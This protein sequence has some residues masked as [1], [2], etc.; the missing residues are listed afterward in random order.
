MTLQAVAPVPLFLLEYSDIATLGSNL[1]DANGE[2][3]AAVFQAPKAGTID[4]VCFRTALVTTG[5]TVDVRLETVGA[6]GNPSGTLVGTNTNASQVINATDDNVWFE[7]TLTA[8]AVVTAGQLIAIVVALPASGAVG[9]MNIARYRAPNGPGLPFTTLFTGTW[10]KLSGYRP[11]A[12]VRYNDGSYPSIVGVLP[13]SAYTANAYNS[14]SSPDERG[15]KITLPVACKVIGAWFVSSASA[16]GDYS[17]KLYNVSD[18]LLTSATLDGDAQFP[19]AGGVGYVYFDAEVTLAAS[20]VVRL[21]KL[22]TTVTN[23]D[24]FSIT[25]GTN[26]AAALPGGTA[27]VRTTR[28]DA[29]AWTDT[30]GQ[31]H[32]IGLIVSALDDGASSG[33]GARA[34]G[35]VG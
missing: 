21:T 27:V 6:D 4:R 24:L 14:G 22:P 7:V 3:A 32:L 16:V 2:K 15:N 28:T 20:D 19:V 30:S 23:T 18:T 5:D 29:G 1:I 9:V 35:F 8:G 10:S 33:G 12:A 31:Q 13:L 17:I 34:Y 25:A 26:A 11:I